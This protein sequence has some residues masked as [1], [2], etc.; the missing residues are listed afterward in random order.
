MT[1]TQR[2]DELKRIIEDIMIKKRAQVDL[3]EILLSPYLIYPLGLWGLSYLFTENPHPAAPILAGLALAYIH[4]N[5]GKEIRKYLGFKTLPERVGDFTTTVLPTVG[6]VSSLAAGL[7]SAGKFFQNARQ[8]GKASHIK[9]LLTALD[10]ELARSTAE[11]RRNIAVSDI[12][13]WAKVRQLRDYVSQQL[14]KTKP[15]TPNPLTRSIDKAITDFMNANQNV[16]I[17]KDALVPLIVRKAETEFI[18][19]LAKH[20]FSPPPKRPQAEPHQE[21]IRSALAQAVT[22]ALKGAETEASRL[23][24]TQNP[25]L[26]TLKN[27]TSTGWVRANAWPIGLAMA[28][29]GIPAAQMLLS[30]LSG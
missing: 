29:I 9:N 26:M 7:Y 25:S 16:T 12:S 2:K 18:D 11:L 24:Q 22:Q 8:D 5:Y 19:A 1:E 6:G 30:W 14:F 17:S 13:D 3:S 21:K 28:A 20:H 10:T 27:Q 15:K 4:K 23:L